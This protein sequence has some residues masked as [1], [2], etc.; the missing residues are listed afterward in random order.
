MSPE[1]SDLDRLVLPNQPLTH[2]QIRLIGSKSD[3]RRRGF[4]GPDEFERVKEY[5][6]REDVKLLEA[7]ITVSPPPW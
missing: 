2:N 6:S 1:K 5:S 3:N 7:T 4:H